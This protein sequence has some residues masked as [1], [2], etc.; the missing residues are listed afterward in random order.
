MNG[1]KKDEDNIAVL[2]INNVRLGKTGRQ[3]AEMVSP[4]RHNSLPFACGR[5]VADGQ[6]IVN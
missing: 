1:G 5:R 2:V 4:L 3:L 6:P